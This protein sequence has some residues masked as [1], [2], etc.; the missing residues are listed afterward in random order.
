MHTSWGICF[1]DKREQVA[2]AKPRNT[3]R[4]FLAERSWCRRTEWR[5]ENKGGAQNSKRLSSRRGKFKDYFFYSEY[6]WFGEKKCK[7]PTRHTCYLG[8][9]HSREPALPLLATLLDRSLAATQDSPTERRSQ[10]RSQ[11]RTWLL[12]QRLTSHLTQQKTRRWQDFQ[13]PIACPQL[14]Q[15][16]LP[17]TQSSFWNRPHFRQQRHAL[18]AAPQQD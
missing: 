16:P 14:R 4:I 11:Q 7:Y 3:R 18:E 17:A 6:S 1:F 2:S 13:S 15:L 12:R 9:T 10:V 8:R 5:T